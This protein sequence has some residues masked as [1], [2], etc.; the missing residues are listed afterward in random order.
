MSSKKKA[1]KKLNKPKSLKHTKPLSLGSA[2]CNGV[3]IKS[4]TLT[5]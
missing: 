2:C 3:H 5:S 4:A 1:K